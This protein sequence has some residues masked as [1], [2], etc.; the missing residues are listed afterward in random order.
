[1]P[2]VDICNAVHNFGENRKF[3][4]NGLLTALAN[5]IMSVRDFST[6]FNEDVKVDGNYRISMAGYEIRRTT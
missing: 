1:M 4:D 3:T 6:S 2:G 5:D